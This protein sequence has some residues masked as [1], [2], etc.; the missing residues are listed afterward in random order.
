MSEMSE[1]SETTEREE[2]GP[3]GWC[4][5]LEGVINAQTA[6]TKPFEVAEMVMHDDSTRG[7]LRLWV[8]KKAVFMVRHC[9]C[10]G[11][12]PQARYKM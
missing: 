5:R 12:D 3:A 6:L 2:C 9:P 7:V 4:G 11:G 10:C 1:M 8:G